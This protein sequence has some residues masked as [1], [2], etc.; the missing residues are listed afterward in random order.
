[1]SYRG[2]ILSGFLK[3]LAHGFDKVYRAGA[4]LPDGD[5]EPKYKRP[6]RL[7][8]GISRD[9]G[10]PIYAGGFG[11]WKHEDFTF[12]NEDSDGSSNGEVTFSEE[13]LFWWAWNWNEVHA[14]EVEMAEER[15]SSMLSGRRNA[16]LDLNT[17]L[18][19]LF[20]QLF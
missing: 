12:L 4:M 6:R 16:I 2:H 8:I 1:M 14:E 3:S 11:E 19:D 5:G 20:H 7:C 13:T 9:K 17:S 15:S 10:K 18:G